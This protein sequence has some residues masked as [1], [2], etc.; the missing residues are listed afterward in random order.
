MQIRYDGPR[1]DIEVGDF[2]PHKKGEV[3][4]YPDEFG[5][6]LLATSRKQKFVAVSSDPVPKPKPKPKSKPNPKTED[7]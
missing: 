5:E 7:K 2:G 6:A 1:S 3:K 4:E